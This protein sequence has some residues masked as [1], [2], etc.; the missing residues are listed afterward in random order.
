MGRPIQKKW[1]TA[2]DG[3]VA[4][5][6]TVLT[7]AGAKVIQKQTGTGVY[8]VDEGRVKLM[9]GA[10][11][12]AADGANG[13]VG[14][15]QL[16][17]DG[18]NVRRINQFRLTYFP[19]GDAGTKDDAVWRD[20]DGGIVGVF[21]PVLTP[22]GGVPAPVVLGAETTESK[23]KT[24]AKKKVKDDSFNFFAGDDPVTKSDDDEDC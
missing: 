19:D 24:K 3:S 11:V 15:A 9:D 6:L 2:K 17:H 10:P 4:G 16:I 14:D 5:D 7:T 1:F 23:P 12:V 22:E 20:T 18:R 8:V 13:I 21:S